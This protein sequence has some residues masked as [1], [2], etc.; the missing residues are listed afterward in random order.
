M[1]RYD[2]LELML[3]KDVLDSEELSGFYQNQ[4]GGKYIQLLEGMFSRYH[5]GGE[6]ITVSNGTS[7]IYCALLALGIK[8]G[9]KVITTPLTFVGTVS[10]IIQVGAEPVFV[11]V[12]E[13]T[14]NLS[15][16][17]LSEIPSESAKAVIFVPLLGNPSGLL[18]IEKI[19]YEKGWYLIEDNAQALGATANVR[20]IGKK[21]I[22][23]TYSFQST[24][25]MSCGEGGMVLVSLDDEQLRP[26]ET[27]P[28]DIVEA[29]RAIRNH[30]LK[31]HGWTKSICGNYRMSELQAAVAYAQ[32]MKID[33]FN[34]LQRRA[35]ERLIK[36][37][38]DAMTPQCVNNGY[39]S[40]RFITGFNADNDGPTA[41]HILSSLENLPVNKKK[42]GANIGHGYSEIVPDLAYFKSRG[43][44]NPYPLDV[45]RNLTYGFVWL[46][47]RWKTDEE[48]DVIIRQ[49]EEVL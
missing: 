2:D 13:S 29:V 44:K 49:I 40:T 12:D 48:M 42:P 25:S 1:K 16:K 35:S 14:W 45:A 11:D 31:Y 10:P 32:M 43:F 22:V 30:G 47:F 38:G 26:H 3:L 34:F 23:S 15:P 6:A 28:W 19:C 24:K 39:E 46:D 7:A 36:V 8:P 4:R 17:L 37:V 20:R 5:G 41:D 33:M 27:P 9:D 21:G 18:E